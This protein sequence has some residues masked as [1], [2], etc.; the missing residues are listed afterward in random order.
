MIEGWRVYVSWCLSL[1]VLLL[2]MSGITGTAEAR[3]IKIHA[4]PPTLVDLP[5]SALQVRI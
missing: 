2:A 1:E 3:L 5:F 4:G